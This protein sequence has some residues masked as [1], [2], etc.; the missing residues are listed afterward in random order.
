MA[1]FWALCQQVFGSNF[2][3]IGKKKADIWPKAKQK[4]GFLFG[5]KTQ[6]NKALQHSQGAKVSVKANIAIFG[7]FFGNSSK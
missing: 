7:Y 6:V 4:V 2:Q 1:S 3:I 5:D